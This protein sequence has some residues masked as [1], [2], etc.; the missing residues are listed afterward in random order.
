MLAYGHSSVVVDETTPLNVHPALKWRTDL[1]I[2]ILAE[3]RVDSLVIRPSM[4]YGL[5]GSHSAPF[6]A[7]PGEKLVVKGSA[8]SHPLTIQLL[9]RPTSTAGREEKRWSWVHVA[10]LTQ[11]FVLAVRRIAVSKGQIFNICSYSA[12][13]VAELAQK[14]AALTG[15]QGPIEY[16]VHL[17]LRAF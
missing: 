13:T 17:L 11:A 7:H 5:S 4:V 3:T 16:Q 9:N 10:D 12:P 6:F 8:F 2:A 1:E 14:A 15:F